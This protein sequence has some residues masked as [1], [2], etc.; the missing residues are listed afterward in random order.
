[1]AA[2]ML[3]T[4][5]QQEP[6]SRQHM[7]QTLVLCW[8]WWSDVCSARVHEH[9]SW[10]HLDNQALYAVGV[11][12]LPTA[13]QCYNEIF[14]GSDNLQQA[15][16]A[17]LCCHG[18]L[19]LCSNA[20]LWSRCLNAANQVPLMQW[21]N[22]GHRMTASAMMLLQLHWLISLQ[23]PF[24]TKRLDWYD[25]QWLS[26]PC[27]ECLQPNRAWMMADMAFWSAA[28]S[29]SPSSLSIVSHRNCCSAECRYIACF[30]KH[31]DCLEPV[32]STCMAA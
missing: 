20:C 7:L 13:S 29:T 8:G 30:N 11:V 5:K 31:N 6:G 3:V 1:M 4:P 14:S 26:S 22:M 21:D 15:G 17:W 24:S 27:K 23:N 28:S 16:I 12:S 32:L 18:C 9:H 25:F 19:C 2:A 10:Y